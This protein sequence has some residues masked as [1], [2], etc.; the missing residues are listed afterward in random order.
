M[1]KHDRSRTERGFAFLEF[2]DIYDT[3]CILQE[4]SWASRPALWLGRSGVQMHLDQAMVGRLIPF[5]QR[6]V[7]TG[8]LELTHVTVIPDTR[9]LCEYRPGEIGRPFASEPGHWHIACPV[10]GGGNGL[11]SHQVIQHEDG[12]LTIR[13]SVLCHSSNTLGPCSAHYLVEHNQIRW[14]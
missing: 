9:D 13:P 7:E 8:K 1:A 4:S 5:L 6:F 10:C 2:Q 12:T 3:T 11:A 14:V